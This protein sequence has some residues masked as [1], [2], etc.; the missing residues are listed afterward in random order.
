MTEDACDPTLIY[1][2]GAHRGEDTEFYL[3]KGFRVVAIEA[4]PRLSSMLSERFAAEIAADRLT[5]LNTAIVEK[6]GPVDFFANPGNTA[7]GTTRHEWAERNQRLGS[8][9]RRIEVEGVTFDTVLR[10]FGMPYFLKIDIEGCDTL[11]LEALRH[12]PSR[13]R[14]VSLE[15]TKTSWDDLVAEFDLLESLGYRRFKVVAQHRVSRQVAAQPARE[16]RYAAHRFS[17]GSSGQFGDEAPG[18]WVDRAAALAFYRPIFM[19]YALFGDD[20]LAHRDPA[21]KAHLARYFPA[22]DEVGWFDTHAALG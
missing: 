10:R 16:G 18:N 3:K 14:Y 22:P 21:T 17:F 15:S 9:F 13:P 12:F 6:A 2:V 5:V 7:W 1:D 20:G 11:C 19:T 4:G 8:P